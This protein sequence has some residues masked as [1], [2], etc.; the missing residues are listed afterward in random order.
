MSR[1]VHHLA[2]HRATPAGSS[3]PPMRSRVLRVYRWADAALPRAS[4]GRML[5][6]GRI[7]DVCA[8]LDRLARTEA[9]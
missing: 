6:S 9:G 8:E 3:H 5:L 4:A 7:A 2:S 1:S